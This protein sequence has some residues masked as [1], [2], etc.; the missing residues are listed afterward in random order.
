ML[1][2]AAPAP[3]HSL[4][5][6][7]TCYRSMRPLVHWWTRPSRLLCCR[8]GVRYL[9]SRCSVS[10][11]CV[12]LLGCDSA[13]D[14]ANSANSDA[15]AVYNRHTG[16]TGL[17]HGS[18][19]ASGC[20]LRA[21]VLCCCCQR[22]SLHMVVVGLWS[23]LLLLRLHCFWLQRFVRLMFIYVCG[24]YVCGICRPIA[25]PPVPVR[26]AAVRELFERV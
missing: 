6:P 17:C 25:T 23:S 14:A 13:V 20:V 3:A 26:S 11:R 15:A 10:H 8:S 19:A 24:L 1:C 12:S 5:P 7:M 9:Y 2:T 18:C 4:S 16:S 21:T 22:V